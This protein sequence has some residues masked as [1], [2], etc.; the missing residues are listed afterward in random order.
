V[1]RRVKLA[2][3]LM[4]LSLS[5]F[6]NA[7]LLTPNVMSL[8]NSWATKLPMPSARL[9][10][11]SAV[12]NGKIY[13]IGGYK[14]QSGFLSTNEE[15]DPVTNT[16]TVKSPMPTPR[17][18]F[19]IAVWQNKI[20][21]IGGATNT[22]LTGIVEVYDPFSD[23][24]TEKTSM[25]TKRDYL[26]ASVVNDKIYLIGG[27]NGVAPTGL[28]NKNEVYDPS[29]DSWTTKAP[30]PTPVYAYASAVVGNKIF[31]LGGLA[32]GS[33]ATNATQVYD[34]STNTWDFAA[35]MSRKVIYAAAGSTIQGTVPERIYVLGGVEQGIAINYNQVY[36][37]I[38]NAWTLGTSMPTNRGWLSVV[39]VNDTIYAI[40]GFDPENR[41]LTTNEQYTPF[42]YGSL[43]T[44]TASVTLNSTMVN[45]GTNVSV[46]VHVTNGT[47]KIEDALVQLVSDKGGTFTPQSGYTNSN[48]DFAAIFTAPSVSTQTIVKITATA[49]KMSYFDGQGQT[50]ITTSPGQPPPPLQQ[51]DL[52]SLIYIVVIV[53]VLAGF[54]VVAMT[55]RR[56]HKT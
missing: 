30:L 39:V 48:G 15:Y 52:T 10:L 36:D 33:D 29:L 3:L 37:P 14:D 13:A 43:Q 12:V 47:T 24:W 11:G 51:P 53:T 22:T 46:Q 31:I 44:L 17:G 2:F 6:V 25:P 50:Q 45:S 8:E 38:R 26:C 19:G 21:V 5:V 54:G 35:A 7:R 9:S 41:T 27:N 23:S 18:G 34:P 42:G 16:W 40:G 56:S 28:T 32:G 55:R 4:L 20:Y 49:S 1:E